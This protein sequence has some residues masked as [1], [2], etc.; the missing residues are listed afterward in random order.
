VGAA[1]A[2]DAELGLAAVLAGGEADVD[3]GADALGAAVASG[4]G[5]GVTV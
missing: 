5:I 3:G 4:S 1:G 2:A